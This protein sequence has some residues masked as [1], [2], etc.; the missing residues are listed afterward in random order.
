MANTAGHLHNSLKLILTQD[1]TYCIVE[2]FCECKFLRK[3]WLGPQ[4]NISQFL[5]LQIRL[6]AVT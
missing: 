5:I 6:H 2:N 4:K 3:G 1:V